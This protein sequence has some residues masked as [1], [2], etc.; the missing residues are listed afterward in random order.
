MTLKRG[1]RKTATPVNSCAQSRI[2]YRVGVGGVWG[3]IGAEAC[4]CDLYLGQNFFF[5]IDRPNDDRSGGSGPTCP[6][7]DPAVLQG[8][9]RWTRSERSQSDPCS[10]QQ[11]FTAEALLS[12]LTLNHHQ[13]LLEFHPMDLLQQLGIPL[14]IATGALGL[15]LAIIAGMGLFGRKNRLP[16]EGRVCLC[17]LFLF[18][19]M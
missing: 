18:L 2:R 3:S 17:Y 12:S 15:I 5:S 1:R 14:P 10:R 9:L 4:C 6:V 16:V 7:P 11:S 19:C 8:P 13:S